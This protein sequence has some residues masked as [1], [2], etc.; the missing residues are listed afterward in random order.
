MTGDPEMI[1]LTTNLRQCLKDW[2][3]LILTMHRSA[4]LVRELVTRALYYIGYLDT[5]YLGAGGMWYS[6]IKTLPPFLWA[7]KWPR[8]IQEAIIT[9][10]NLAR[11]MKMNN[12][13]LAGPLLSLL[14]LEAWGGGASFTRI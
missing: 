5:C 9:D 11:D 7:V 1:P 6:G 8:D 13:E 10:A 12:L 14:A 2:R 4:I 3:F